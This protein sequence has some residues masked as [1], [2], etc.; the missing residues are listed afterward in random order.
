MARRP[1][2]PGTCF[3]C[4][5]TFP[6]ASMTRHLAKCLATHG[7]AE[8]AAA[9]KAKKAT[10]VHV[11][12]EGK[13]QPQY[14]LH[15]EMPAKTRLEDLDAFLRD[16]W[17]ECCDH[18]SAFKREVPKKRGVPRTLA[19][20]LAANPFDWADDDLGMDTKVGTVLK[21]DS[22]LTYEYDF[23]STTTLTL[24][25][26]GE[27]E[28]LVEDPR[29]VR[30]LARNDPPFI[31]C[32]RCHKNAAATID[33]EESYDES[34][35]LCEACAEKAGLSEDEMTLPVVNSPRT[36]VCGYTGN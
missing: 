35:W 13:Y 16:I 29:E 20:M 9:R 19:D 15:L 26:V 3:L 25:G 11:L 36:G 24:K 7:D 28:G 6:K 31:P 12:V 4:K 17:V 33:R 2:T 1:S 21:K 8:H 5:G 10:L 32:G 18:M 30:L 22:K 34:G 23:G 27:R 14:W